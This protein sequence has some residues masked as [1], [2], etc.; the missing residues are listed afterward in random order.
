[1][2]RAD[3]IR[4]LRKELLRSSRRFFDINSNVAAA[5]LLRHRPRSKMVSGIA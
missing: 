1:M 3:R 2:V 5:W 4:Q